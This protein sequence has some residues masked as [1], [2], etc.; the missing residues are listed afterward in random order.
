MLPY[1]LD[2]IDAAVFQEVCDQRTSESST[3]DFKQTLP[4]KTDDDKEELAKDVSA[5][6]NA[7]GGDLVYGITEDRASGTAKGVMPIEIG[8][9]D[10][11]SRRITQILDAWI[12][13]RYRGIQIVEVELDG[14]SGVVIRVPMSFDGPHWVR[15]PNSTKRRFVIR[16]GKM[17]S[18]M[19]YDQVRS[20]FNATASL[21]IQARDFTKARLTLVE[22]RKMNMPM[23]QSPL[24]VLEL[25]SLAGLARR[26]SVDIKKVQFVDFIVWDGGADP[27]MNLDG[28]GAYLGANGEAFSQSQLFR[29]GSME[30][31][32]IVGGSQDGKMGVWASHSLQFFERSLR[33]SLEAARKYDIAGPALVT[34][35]LMHVEGCELAL[36]SYSPFRKKLADRP[37][38]V[39]P[40]IYIEDLSGEAD[41]DALLADTRDV[42]YQAFGH[43]AAPAKRT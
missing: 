41:V 39:F 9:F 40:E 33:V 37:F 35:A 28:A 30:Y 10:K 15:N 6:L 17:T 27:K 16:N 34:C 20:A 19:S 24:A 18:D 23:G 8:N 42:L 25:V 43:S 36:D 29:N 2:K 26:S 13:P 31:M 4:G 14:G 5:L 12:E 1:A 38:M 7:D 22:D 32:T 3:L 11:E 21:A